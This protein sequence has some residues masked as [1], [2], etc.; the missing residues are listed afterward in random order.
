MLVTL[1][2]ES[3]PTPR[4]ATESVLPKTELSGGLVMVTLGGELAAL[5]ITLTT[6]EVV[7]SPPLSVATAVSGWLPAARVAVTV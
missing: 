4:T 7:D 6:A 2:S 3:V 5:T 1:P